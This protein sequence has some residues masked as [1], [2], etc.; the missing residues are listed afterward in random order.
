MLFMLMLT[1]LHQNTIALLA[2]FNNE[3]R[4]IR[5]ESRNTHFARDLQTIQYEIPFA[6][7]NEMATI[8]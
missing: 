1:A 6:V 4:Q 7:H 2:V 3:D 8:V 5:E